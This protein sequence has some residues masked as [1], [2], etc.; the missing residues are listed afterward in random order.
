MT[1]STSSSTEARA[2][3]WAAPERAQSKQVG[4]FFEFLTFRGQTRTAEHRNSAEQQ[5]RDVFR[6]ESEL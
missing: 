3:A 6:F 4:V 2:R 1:P 5:K